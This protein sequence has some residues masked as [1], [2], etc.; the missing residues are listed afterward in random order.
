MSLKSG[1]PF[2]RAHIKA[3]EI[4]IPCA[5]IPQ[6]IHCLPMVHNVPRMVELLCRIRE[7]LVP[8]EPGNYAN[9]AAIILKDMGVE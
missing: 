1:S 4:Y 2:L 5:G 7:G 9:A 3:G 8:A 6:A